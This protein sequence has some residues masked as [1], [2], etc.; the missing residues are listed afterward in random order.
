M[1]N[2]HH[3]KKHK[4]FQP[5]P[6]HPADTRKSSGRGSIVMSIIGGISGLIVSY[7]GAG[8]NYLWLVLGTAAGIILG[9]LFGKRL[10]KSFEKS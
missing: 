6:H 7:M 9:Y 10:D 4:H 5:P 1:A 8:D 3:R 2:P